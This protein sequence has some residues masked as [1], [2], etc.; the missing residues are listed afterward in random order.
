MRLG[1]CRSRG[2]ARIR[3]L[4]FLIVPALL[5]AGCGRDAQTSKLRLATTHTLEDSGLLDSLT[6]AFRTAHPEYD[7]QVVV[8]GSGEALAIGRQGDVDVLLTHA[9]ELERAFV[10]SEYAVSR[11]PVMHND[12]IVAGPATDPAGVRGATDA[13]DAFRRIHAAKQ[14]FVSR[15]DNSGTHE[16]ELSL[17]KAAGLETD[18][19]PYS[20]AGVGM[21]DALRIAAQRQ[22]Y[23]LSDVATFIAL[24]D[25]LQLQQLYRGDPIMRNVYSVIVTKNGVNRD[26]A[27]AFAAWVTSEAARNLIAAYGSQRFG[28]PL[29]LPDR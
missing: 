23:I 20:E 5:F 12:F 21:A 16:K 24:R 11:A 4:M 2:C 18:S 28:E 13:R 25:E 17:W 29:F 6:A 10:A 26:G 1:H 7:L 9:P 27:N 22:A 15:G 14:P 19:L 8:A 3:R